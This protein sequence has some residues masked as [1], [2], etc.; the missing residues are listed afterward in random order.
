VRNAFVPGQPFTEHHGLAGEQNRRTVAI[1][2]FIEAVD[3]IS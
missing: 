1:D 3:A 2:R